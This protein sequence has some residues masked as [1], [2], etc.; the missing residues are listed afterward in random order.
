MSQ[1]E[2]S[3]RERIYCY[4]CGKSSDKPEGDTL[5]CPA[6]VPLQDFDGNAV[7]GDDGRI[8]E[9]TCMSEFVE[10][11]EEDDIDTPDEHMGQE[12]EGHLDPLPFF[13]DRSPQGDFGGNVAYG[14]V[15]FTRTGPGS[16]RV[17]HSWSGP[18][19]QNATEQ[20]LA[21]S[22]IPNCVEIPSLAIFRTFLTV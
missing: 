15:E 9:D 2:E 13:H 1:S 17:V 5:F 4:T 19:R 18:G 3:R 16:V 8:V 14:R 11:I 21:F 7:T 12:H 20:H 6:I 10:I 22:I